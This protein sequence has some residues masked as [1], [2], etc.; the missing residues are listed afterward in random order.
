MISEVQRE[1]GPTFLIIFCQKKKTPWELSEAA[2]WQVWEEKEQIGEFG[3]KAGLCNPSSRT[4]YLGV[5]SPVMPDIG[6]P[7]CLFSSG[8]HLAN[9]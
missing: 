3:S 8:S 1:K 7:V 6:D 4:L 5:Y 2:N 9:L